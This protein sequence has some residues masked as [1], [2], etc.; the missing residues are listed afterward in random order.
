MLYEYFS[1]IMFGLFYLSFFAMFI[2]VGLLFLFMI[3]KD[4]YKKKREHDE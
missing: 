1:F 4:W 2:L 3:K